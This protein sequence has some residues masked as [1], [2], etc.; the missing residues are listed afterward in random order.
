MNRAFLTAV[1]VLITVRVVTAGDFATEMMEAT[2]KLGRGAS[3]TCFLVRREAPDTAVYLVTVGHAFDDNTDETAVVVLRTPQP[4]GSYQ[5]RDHTITL[6]R[7]GKPLWARHAKHD[8]AVLRISEPLP[9]VVAALPASALADAALLKASAVHLCSPLFVLSYPK[10]LEANAAGLPVARQG[11]FASP[12]LL[13]SATH[14]SFLADYNAF[15]GDSGGPVFIAGADNHPL[16]V[17]IV[18][19]QHYYDDELKG[20]YQQHRIRNPLGVVKIL[21]AQY[22]RETLEAAAKQSEPPSK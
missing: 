6:R 16:L 1:L 12:P 13:P 4:D 21:H 18:T 17:G 14:P 20:M 11:I 2:F 9:V 8:V 10:G 19:D 7:D 15:Q 22:V 5:R 3:G